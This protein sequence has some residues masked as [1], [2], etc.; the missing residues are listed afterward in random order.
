MKSCLGPKGA[1]AMLCQ[2]IE[3]Q[4]ITCRI[5]IRLIPNEWLNSLLLFFSNKRKKERMEMKENL[6]PEERMTLRY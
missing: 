2:L 1:C 3:W 5:Q 4:Q 6:K